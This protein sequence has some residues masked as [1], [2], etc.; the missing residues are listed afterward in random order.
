MAE[1]PAD[2]F[3]GTASVADEMGRSEPPKALDITS[4]MV[5]ADCVRKM[6]CRRVASWKTTSDSF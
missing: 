3:C 1:V 4:R 5:G 6:V 2:P